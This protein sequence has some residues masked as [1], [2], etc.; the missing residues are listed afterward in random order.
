MAANPYD[1]L[2]VG[3]DASDEQIRSAYRAMAKRHHPD[4]RGGDAA[5][6]KAANEAYGLLIDPLRR[7]AF[8]R[9]TARSGDASSTV[10]VRVEPGYAPFSA[11]RSTRRAPV[12]PTQE[13]RVN[14]FAVEYDVYLSRE[15]AAYGVTAAIGVGSGRAVV[16]IPPGIPDG[17]RLQTRPI[18][19]VLRPIVLHV[20]VRRG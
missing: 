2:G 12:E 17:T 14:P 1:T 8:D 7:T 9:K 4:S 18:P 20:H 10:D 3:C 19:G 13:Y 5:A 6:F 16:A 11:H 15:E